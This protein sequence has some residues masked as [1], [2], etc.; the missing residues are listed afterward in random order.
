MNDY[1]RN[2]FRKERDENNI[3]HYYF[4]INR[5]FI[6]VNEE[7]FRTCRNSYEKIRRD[8]IK[9]RDMKILSLDYVDNNGLT[10]LDQISYESEKS[11]ID[12]CLIDLINCELKILN[13]K[14]K[15][16]IYE[17][18]FN[19]HSE[20]EVAKMFGCTRQCI[21]KRKHAILNKIKEKLN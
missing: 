3:S 20:S 17:I 8:N 16:I 1:K 9:F 13:D 11:I 21:H 7:V 2:Y 5:E 14:D 19:G 6:E 4:Y 15:R 18:Y 12:K 10:L